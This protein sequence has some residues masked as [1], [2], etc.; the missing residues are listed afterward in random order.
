MSPDV[1]VLFCNSS[2][3]PLW[4][5]WMYICR[6]CWSWQ[7]IKLY[8]RRK[9]IPVPEQCQVTQS[10]TA[11]LSPWGGLEP[12]LGEYELD[13]LLIHATQRQSQLLQSPLPCTRTP[14][15]ARWHAN[16]HTSAPNTHAHACPH[17]R[18]MIDGKRHKGQQSAGLHL[19]RTRLLLH[20][21]G[22]GDRA[23][24]HWSSPQLLEYPAE[25]SD[26]FKKLQL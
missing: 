1:I 12:R 19:D 7:K 25:V 4:S 15:C 10:A 6:Y 9:H 20:H 21:L 3:S 16:S 8:T 24:P 14:Q 11:F 18:S 17:A 22:F 2:P 13:R 5:T 26:C 23:D